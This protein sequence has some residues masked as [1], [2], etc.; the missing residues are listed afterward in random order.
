M[1]S[2]RAGDTIRF[3][4]NYVDFPIGQSISGYKYWITVKSD[5]AHS[6][7]LAI[8]Q[9]AS[10]AG[11]TE[12]D[13]VGT[14]GVN[15]KVVTIQSGILAPGDYVFDIQCKTASGDIMT[16]IPQADKDIAR[17]KIRPQ[18]TQATV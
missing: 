6:D 3:V 5:I 9:I 4:I 16:I 13:V 7:A 11:E 2:Y 12:G 1:Y 8:T 15:V 18:V 17:L 10:M 14:N